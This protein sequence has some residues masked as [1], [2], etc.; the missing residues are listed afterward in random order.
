MRTMEKENGQRHV[1]NKGEAFTEQKCYFAN[2]N[3]GWLHG[4]GTRG[5]WLHKWCVD[6][7]GPIKVK[8]LKTT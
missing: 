4:C 7:A 8:F 1:Q 2:D 6:P 3:G 5:C